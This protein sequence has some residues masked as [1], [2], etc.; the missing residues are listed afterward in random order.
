MSLGAVTELGLLCTHRFA[1][2]GDAVRSVL[3]L[4]ER[5][6]PP[7]RVIFGELNYNTDEYRVLDTRGEGVDALSTGV[8][9]PLRESFCVH[10]ASDATPALIGRVSKDPVYGELDLHKSAGVQSYVAAPV[11]LGDG[12]RVASVCAMSTDRD[13]YGDNE[14]AL[15]TIAARLIAYEWEHVT[16][17]GELRRLQQRRS[18]SGDPLT[19]LP[20]RDAFLEQLD[21]Q[22]HLTQRGITESYVV[23]LKPLGIEE[24][25]AISGD[26]VGDLLLQSTGEVISADVRRS[27]IAGRVGDD[28]FAVIL[29]GC[30]GLEGAEAFRSRLQGTF[31]RKLR[32]RPE[33]LEL[34]YGIERLNDADSAA[35]ALELAEDALEAEAV[36]R[37]V[38]R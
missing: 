35:A 26:A 19:G 6:L 3:T 13:R 24:A 16:R 10:M 38:P 33:K 21:R 2:L 25:R 5:Q 1:S 29:V 34:A 9:L 27:D 31:E 22:W 17:E 37:A 14:L 8:R 11:E 20:L 12:T 15:L 4:L 18:L 7:G 36:G 23:A 28:V 30:R 32:Q